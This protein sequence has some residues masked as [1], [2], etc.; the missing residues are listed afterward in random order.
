MNVQRP[1]PH[2]TRLDLLFA[3]LLLALSG[4]ALL[5][6]AGIPFHP[7]E[8]TQ[9]YMSADFDSLA[10]PWTMA[11]S[12]QPQDAQRQHYR[13]IDAALTRYLL[14]L[15]RA[16]AGLP[17]LPAD[18]DWAASW[19]QNR[20]AGALPA[21]D[22]LLA[23]R[24]ATTLLLPFSLLFIYM[25]GRNSGRPLAGLLAALLLGTNALTL[26]H[27]RRAMAEGPLLFGVSLFLYSLPGAGRR[28]WLTALTAALA[29]NAKQS[30]LALL[31]VGLL[32]VAWLPGEASE[33]KKQAARSSLQYA[34]VFFLVTAALNPVWWHRPL[35]ALRA[36]LAERQ[37]LLA[38][39]TADAQRVNPG[40][41]LD[42]PAERLAALLANLY[43]TPP[44]FAELGN[45]LDQ[46][47]AAEAAYLQIPGNTLL[48]GL[49]GGGV[50]LFLTLLGLI[51]AGLRLRR[52]D[53]AARRSLALLLLAT[54]S[55]V[56]FQLVAVPL[57]WQRYVM[58]LL[59]L[60]CWWA[61]YAG[62]EL[63]EMLV[64]IGRKVVSRVRTSKQTSAQV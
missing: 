62:E 33:R 6:A 55:Q 22:L 48:R 18:W 36:S 41:Y 4:Y 17:P 34:A 45:Y 60:A 49:A 46:T 35:P 13:M 20:Q 38:R 58:P 30:A 44:A 50:L 27:A 37:D 5:G 12:P 23:G 8:S 57:S 2:L 47:A 52:T 39:Q 21:P 15:G 59:P 29:F 1:Q 64:V 14:G 7:D 56:A 24:L 61:G 54:G 32:A 9:L 26:L 42:S 28:P 63:G 53:P 16:V 3:I 31:P 19:E 51:L 43:L 25:L 40:Q 10:A 11:W